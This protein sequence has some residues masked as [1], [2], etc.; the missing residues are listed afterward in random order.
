MDGNLNERVARLEEKIDM[1][2]LLRA[3]VSDVQA[4]LRELELS[5]RSLETEVRALRNGH[6]SLRTMDF[7]IAAIYALALAAMAIFFGGKG[8]R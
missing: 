7:F 1:L 2:L 6:R 5:V 8:I 3:D 4:R